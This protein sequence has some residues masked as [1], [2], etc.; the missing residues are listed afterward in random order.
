MIKRADIDIIIIAIFFLLFKVFCEIFWLSFKA[1]SKV[2]LILT[3]EFLATFIALLEVWI[4]LAKSIES[5][6]SFDILNKI[7]LLL[8]FK[9]NNPKNRKKWIK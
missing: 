6:I 9:L 5:Y 2:D 1:L 7:I 4:S 8:V 3:S